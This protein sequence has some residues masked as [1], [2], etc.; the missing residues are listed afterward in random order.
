MPL[1]RFADALGKKEFGSKDH[2]ADLLTD[3]LPVLSKDILSEEH[4]ARLHFLSCLN[5]ATAAEA[6]ASQYQ[7]ED[8][9]SSARFALF[10]LTLQPLWTSFGVFAAKKLALRKA[11]LKGCNRENTLVLKLLRSDPLTSSIFDREVVDLVISQAD[12]QAKPV[13]TVL[14]FATQPQKRSGSASRSRSGKRRKS[15][16]QSQQ[17]GQ[18]GSQPSGQR[19]PDRRRR[20]PS[21]GKGRGGGTPG[22]NPPKSPRGRG[23]GNPR[24]PKRPGKE[25]P[26]NF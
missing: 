11:A 24:T 18:S 10:K 16:Q 26:P 5:A 13:L 2:H 8:V 22:R 25:T 7:A 20:S 23:K 21:P 6:L 4:G 14:G 9:P 17:K 19:T 12:H 1:R 15:G 3:R